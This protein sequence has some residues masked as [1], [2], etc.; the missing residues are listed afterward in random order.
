MYRG[1]KIDEALVIRVHIGSLGIRSAECLI[2]SQHDFIMLIGD[3]KPILAI[4]A[5][6]EMVE[7]PPEAANL[8]TRIAVGLRIEAIVSAKRIDRNSI[9]RERPA[10]LRQFIVSEKPE[11]LAH[12]RG[13]AEFRTAKQPIPLET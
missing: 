6:I 8:D 3:G 1:G 12:S 5:Q 10:V 13:P 7:H 11:Q 4:L 2:G 9:S